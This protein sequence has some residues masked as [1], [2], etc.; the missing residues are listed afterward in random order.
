GPTTS[1]L[2]PRRSFAGTGPCERRCRVRFVP[3][4]PPPVAVPTAFAR[5]QQEGVLDR[6]FASSGTRWVRQAILEGSAPIVPARQ[7]PADP[8]AGSAAGDSSTGAVAPG[9][10]AIGASPCTSRI[11]Q[12]GS[13]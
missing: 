2:D 13:A 8:G 1:P 11:Q 12:P 4:D 5:Q 3:A 7:T 10:R 9:R 6:R